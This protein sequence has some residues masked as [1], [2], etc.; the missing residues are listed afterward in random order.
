VFIGLFSLIL[1][2]GLHISDEATYQGH[3]TRAVQKGLRFGM[4]LF[5]ASE[6]MFF[7]GFF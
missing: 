4:V 7:F 3:H 6:V 2:W 1:V 5:I